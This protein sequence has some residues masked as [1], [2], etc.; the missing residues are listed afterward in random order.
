MRFYAVSL[1]ELWWLLTKSEFQN[2]ECW[3]ATYYV[4]KEEVLVALPYIC[5]ILIVN[6]T[7]RQNKTTLYEKVDV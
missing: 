5:R 4:Q 3:M 1:V 6:F 7:H 2:Q